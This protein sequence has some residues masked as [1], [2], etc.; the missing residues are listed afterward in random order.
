M[1]VR[2]TPLGA[3]VVLSLVL[4]ACSGGS[5]PSPSGGASAPPASAGGSAGASASAGSS[6]AASAPASMTASGT[7]NVLAFG[8]T[9]GDDIAKNRIAK[10]KD[11]YPDVDLKCTEGD[12]DP[13]QFLTAV[14]SGNPPDLVYMGRNVLGTYAANQ[15]LQPLDDCVSK[16]GIDMNNFRQAAVQQVT[17]DGK[18]YGIPE[19]F[20]TRIILINN[21]VA[22]D[23]GVSPDD[24]D[25]G[26]WDALKAANDKLF[27]KE[28]GDLK[29]LGFDPKLPEFL[30]LWAKINGADMLSA[31]GKTSNLDDPKIAEALTFA[32]SLITAQAKPSEF[33]AARDAVSKDF[34]GKENPMA[35]DKI[36]AWPMEQWYLN[37]LAENSPD[38]DMTVKAPTTRDGQP[39]SYSDGNVWG[40]PTGAKNMDAACAFMA[41]MTSTDTWAFAAQKRA[42][43]RKADGK[44]CGGTYT[45]NKAADDKIFSEICA[46]VPS[47]NPVFDKAIQTVLQLQDVAFALPPTPAADAF[48]KAWKD[49]VNRV[50]NEGADPT[51]ALQQADEQAQGEIDSAGS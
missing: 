31:D 40:V 42:D 17:I 30:P 15:A 3:L 33:F 7:L 20:N 27:T 50:M 9:Q 18:V 32:V 24:I 49:A 6:A 11:D 4:S 28:G 22:Q 43:A 8:C 47:S 2:R 5:S 10:F 25:M 23:A 19:F 12:F 45:A 37:V 41:D 1:T 21:K 46:A 29:V 14:R 34:F 35:T 39:V 26:N 13:Q 48:D 36:A 38:V 51:Q 16:A 44:P